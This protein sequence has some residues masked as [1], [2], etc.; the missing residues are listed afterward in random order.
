MNGA[1]T[2]FADL[3]YGPPADPPIRACVG[4]ACFAA[5]HG[6]PQLI[7]PDEHVERVY[8]LGY[9]YGGP[10]A[11]DGEQPCAGPDLGGA[12]RRRRRR[13]DPQIPWPVAVDEPV[14]LARLAGAEPGRL[15]RVGHDPRRPGDRERV[16]LDEVKRSGLRG[17]GGAGFPA[18]A[19]VDDGGGEPLRRSPLPG[20]QRRRGRSRARTSTGC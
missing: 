2:F 13:R 1:A 7:A 15:E 8:C 3:G 12:A 6:Q 10:A 14:V 11:L 4:A 16:V 17:R 9:C 5:S 20:R 18:A 19:Q